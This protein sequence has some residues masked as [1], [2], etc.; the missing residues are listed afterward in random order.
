MTVGRTTANFAEPL[1]VEGRTITIDADFTSRTKDDYGYLALEGIGISYGVRPGIGLRYLHGDWG[2]DFFSTPED[3]DYYINNRMIYQIKVDPNDVP[4]AKKARA[5]IN[6]EFISYLECNEV[7]VT[8]ISEVFDKGS[9]IY[10]HVYSIAVEDNVDDAVISYVDGGTQTEKEY[11][12]GSQLTLP[13][14]SSAGGWTDGEGNFYAAGQTIT[15][16]KSMTL[17]AASSASGA[18]SSSSVR[19]YEQDGRT[20]YE[21]ELPSDNA[22]DSLEWS[23][24]L[25]S[26]FGASP[27]MPKLSGKGKFVIT[28]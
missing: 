4:E 6:G 20:Y 24:E 21:F 5:Y 28:K 9:D 25:S 16:S 12:I 7:A 17:T 2:T 13:S 23:S 10:S 11:L 22:Y 18:A 15:A 26:V 27:A 14:P 1:F 8:G 3:T 19:S